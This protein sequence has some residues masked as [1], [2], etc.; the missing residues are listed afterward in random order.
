MDGLISDGSNVGELWS[1]FI[2]YE[3]AYI[4]AY[5]K[6]ML[7]HKTDIAKLKSM[8]DEAYKRW[9]ISAKK[10]LVIHHGNWD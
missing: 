5:G 8:K 4:Q 10:A 6:S 7:G 9:A 3:K 2:S 1:Q